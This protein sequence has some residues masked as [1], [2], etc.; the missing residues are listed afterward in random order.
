[1][2]IFMKAILYVCIS[3]LIALGGLNG[4]NAQS[5]TGK[6]H[7]VK[8]GAVEFASV[9][10]T[11]LNDSTLTKGVLTDTLGVFELTNLTPGSYKLIITSL[12]YKA[13]SN[14][15]ITV[16][17]NVDPINLGVL[18]LIDDTKT[19]QTVVVKGE[20]PVVERTL[21]KLTLNV[22]N[23]FYKTAATAL[24][25]LKRAPGLRIDPQGGITIKGSV[26][27]VVYIDGKQLP[28]TAEELRNLPSEDI[29]QVEIISNA[30]AQYDGETRAVINIK[31]KR[32][33]TLG[34]KGS[35]YVGTSVNRYYGGYELGGSATFK[36]KK[37]TYYGRAGYYESNDFLHEVSKRIVQTNAERTVFSSNAFTHWRNH[38]LSYQASI[39]YSISKSHMVGI[40]ARGVTN[41]Q[42]DFTDNTTQ[43]A[44]YPT[45]IAMFSQRELPTE[46]RTVTRPA[47]VAVDLNYRGTLSS[48]GDQLSVNLDYASYQ[49]AKTQ[50]LR[51]IYTGD[52]TASVSFPSVLLG[53]F[54][55]TISIQSLKA[56]YT[57]LVDNTMRIDLGAKLSLTNTD[58]EL[59]YDTLSATGVMA[60]D[61]R[62][63][64]HFLYNE[65][66]IATYLLVEK[67]MGRTSIEAALR[68]EKTVAEGNSLTLDNVVKRNFIRWLPSLQ[69]Q[70]KLDEKQSLSFSY[71]RK[72]QRPTFYELNPFQFYTSP[73]EYSE[74]NPFLLPAI[75][76]STELAY[77]YKDITLTG[78]YRV[79][80]NLIAQMPIQD[81]ITKVIRY[82]RTNLDKSQL[83]TFDIAAPLKINSWWK[84]QHSAVAYYIRTTS[85]FDEG[86]FDNRA[87]SFVLSG[88]HVFSLPRGYTL[89]YTYDYSAPS[90]SQFYRTISYGTMSFSLQK[91]ILKGAGSIQANFADAFNLYQQKFYG[92][93]QDV[94]VSTIQMRNVQQASIRFTYNYGRS[95]FSRRSRTSGS[96]DEE[97]RA[98]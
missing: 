5:I 61:L 84:T 67:K 54:P 25:I 30:S 73:F 74:G 90:A 85:L 81:E 82:T 33:K 7:N 66:I 65:R 22:S 28:L 15:E 41:R 87:W 24:D 80:R 91:S 63:S 26:T 23:S 10:L 77:T 75:R 38:P 53:Q 52:L 3:F 79:D 32:D 18:Q 98:R 19:L 47:N 95:T 83:V 94:N 21:G 70:Q 16:L 34:L 76:S 57:H 40:M 92:I 12:G 59:I 56:D 27:P 72:L 55:S 43:I 17:A 36:T 68:V 88:Q 71:A 51:T 9:L 78:T 50:T 86:S 64:N 46:T 45:G 8:A 60:R 2:T 13:Y 31:L 6:V 4:V 96:S 1:M 11:A 49:T 39:D 37:L 20:R 58:N 93:F 29:E 89:E 97:N 14:K 44:N 48:T 42:N 62:R 69:I 35:S